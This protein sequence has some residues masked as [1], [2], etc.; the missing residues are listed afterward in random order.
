MSLSTFVKIIEG[1]FY[2]KIFDEEIENILLNCEN[3]INDNILINNGVKSILASIVYLLEIEDEVK[4][5]DNV[6]KCSIIDNINE[7]FDLWYQ[8]HTFNFL[9]N[10]DTILYY[11]REDIKEDIKKIL[12]HLRNG[13]FKIV[14]YPSTYEEGPD[15]VDVGIGFEILYI[16]NK[17]VNCFDL[18]LNDLTSCIYN[19]EKYSFWYSKNLNIYEPNDI[20]Y[21]T[22]NNIK[23]DSILL[24]LERDLNIDNI[25]AL[26]HY[27]KTIH[28]SKI[29]IYIYRD[30]IPVIED[31]LKKMAGISVE[32]YL[33]TYNMIGDKDRES[34]PE[35]PYR[36]EVKKTA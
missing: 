4:L 30:I 34:F 35:D 10:I 24:S 1:E 14:K 32:L 28:Q 16:A 13:N 6:T 5:N 19:K 29:R 20:T 27:H 3:D 21:I 25:E 31:L 11:L 8:V 7:P 26:Y 17:T 9:A 12:P 36:I 22:E 2:S 18:K 15:Y 33:F 23:V